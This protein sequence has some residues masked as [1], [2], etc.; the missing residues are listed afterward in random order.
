VRTGYVWHEIYGWHDTGR[1]AGFLRPGGFVQPYQHF[2]SSES[3]T[4]FAAL[5]EVSGLL[6]HLVRLRATP[7]TEED[8]LRVHDAAYVTRIQAQSM[9]DKGGDAGDG[10]SPFGHGGYEIAAL[11]AGG[12]IAALDAV[13]T[14][15][16]DNAYALVR[17]PGHHARPTTGMG[18]CVFSNA[19]IAIRAMRAQHG[20]ER[21]A[22]VDWDVHHGN[23]TQEI[24][25]A[26]PDTLTISL[27][28]DKLFPQDSGLLSECGVG[29][30]LGSCIN[31]PLPAGS[32]NGAYLATM[33]R[34]VVP[35]LRAFRPDLI[36]VASGFDASAN[37]PLGRMLVTA[38]SF[39]EMTRVL[40]DTAADV[41]AGRLAMT[42]E[43]GYSPVYVPWC[44]LA[45][46]QEMSGVD[47]DVDDPF[48]ASWATLPDQELKPWQESVLLAAAEAAWDLLAQL[49]NLG[50]P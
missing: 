16:V 42:H 32:G 8:L 26:D 25:Y 33:H 18:F 10:D 49:P 19:A 28:Q 6:D 34:V 3:K 47:L 23:G 30:G 29:A 2:E 21:V 39:R 46:L 50:T 11:A 12:T 37:D 17:P 27:H 44:G 48:E 5:V 38:G 40:L 36:V 15:N 20:V 9:L 35:A 45:V 7:A 22:V 13:V 24:F 1:Y 4:R 14:G 43:G 41:C 31:I